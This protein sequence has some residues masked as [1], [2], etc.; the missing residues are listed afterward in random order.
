MEQ[1]VTIELFGKP[2]TF[3]AKSEVKKAKDVADFLAK[4]VSRVESQQSGESS[5]ASDLTTL[6]LAALNIAYQNMELEGNYSK[7]MQDIAERSAK[8]IRK[9]DEHVQEMETFVTS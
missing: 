2:Y 5:T 8:L 3:K 6:L 1:L 7:F 4:E 9:I